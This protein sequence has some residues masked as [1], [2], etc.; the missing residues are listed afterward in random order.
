MKK[1]LFMIT[2]ILIN[3]VYSQDAGLGFGFNLG[4][5]I[6]L[7]YKYWIDNNS[8]LD[9]VFGYSYLKTDGQMDISVVYNKVSYNYLSIYEKKYHVNHGLGLSYSTNFSGSYILGVKANLQLF[10]YIIESPTDYYIYVSPILGLFP[11]V[12]LYMDFGVG[13]RYFINQ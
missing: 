5:P 9:G 11:K 2:F 8:S 12:N 1:I 4:E 10:S 6:G 13:I 7:G 3:F